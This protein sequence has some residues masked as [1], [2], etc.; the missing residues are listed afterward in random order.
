MVY[1]IDSHSNY[2]DFE[3]FFHRIEIFLGMGWSCS[4]LGDYAKSLATS[5]ETIL[6]LFKH[7]GMPPPG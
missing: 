3:H 5:P 7:K 2:C 4:I 6:A 1:L